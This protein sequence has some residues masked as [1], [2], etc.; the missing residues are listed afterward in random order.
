MARKALIF[1]NGLGMALDANHFSLTNAINY[2]WEHESILDDSERR[3][4]EQ[5][6]PGVEGR[7]PEGEHELDILHVAVTACGFL[8]H[9]SGN[10]VEWLSDK[11]K[12]F[13]TTIAKFVHKVATHLHNYEAGELPASFTSSLCEFIKESNSHVA[14]LNYDRLL[15]GAMIDN[16]LLDGYGGNLIDGMIGSGFEY[17]NLERKYGRDFGYYLHLHGS[18]LFVNHNGIPKK[19]RRQELSLDSD[20]T[21]RHIVLT[22]VKH[23]PS[24]I[25]SSSVLTAYWDYLDF[26]L[27]E[28]EEVVVIG[29]SGEDEHLNQKLKRYCKMPTRKT[30]VVEWSGAR[31][32]VE[33]LKL[34]RDKLGSCIE[35]VQMD[36][37]LD[38]DDW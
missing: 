34:W 2:I 11:G 1:G 7:P 25:S 17:D 16:G 5:C 37:I 23:K 10:D 33:S 32:K 9:L 31:S 27:G 28:S 35:L 15:Y 36:N 26:A 4:I 18:P 30:R 29:C 13:P 3:Y 24:V 8:R 22:H 20:F 12:E 21:G 19:K 14:T 6:L 38:F